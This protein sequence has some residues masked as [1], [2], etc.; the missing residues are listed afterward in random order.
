MKHKTLQF[1]N[2]GKQAIRDAIRSVT[3]GYPEPG[4]H[5]VEGSII[6]ERACEWGYTASWGKFETLI[7]HMVENE[8]LAVMTD[9]DMFLFALPPT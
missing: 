9:G 6:Y 8:E 4:I 3:E 5:F 1:S 7:V 2:R